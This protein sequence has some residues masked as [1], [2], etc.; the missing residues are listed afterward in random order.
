M[1]MI[2]SVVI[3]VFQNTFNLEIIFLIFKNYF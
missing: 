2:E 3:V 1:D